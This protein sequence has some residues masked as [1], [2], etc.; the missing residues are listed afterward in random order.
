MASPFVPPSPTYWH[1]HRPTKLCTRVRPT[2]RIHHGPIFP[3]RINQEI[4][5]SAH[6][7]VADMCQD[8]KKIRDPGSTGSRIR[9][10]GRYWILYFHF[11]V[12]SY[13][14]WILSRQHCC[15]I[16]EILDLR[17]D[18]A[19]IWVSWILLGQVIM[20]SGGS[21]ILHNNNVTVSRRSFTSNE[22]LPYLCAA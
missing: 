2:D 11:L 8:P 5:A 6:L 15:G 4:P 22:I 18:V 21:W 1:G 12:G 17:K 20:G 14:S 9:D 3:Q 16:L 19:E 7:C 13:K 10:V